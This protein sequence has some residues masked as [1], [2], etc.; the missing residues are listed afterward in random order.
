MIYISGMLQESILSDQLLKDLVFDK[1][2]F[3]PVGLPFSGLP[4]RHGNRKSISLILL[5]QT[6][7]DRSFSGSAE[8]GDNY[9]FS[10]HLSAS[11]RACG[12]SASSY[13]LMICLCLRFS[14]YKVTFSLPNMPERKILYRQDFSLFFLVGIR[15][16]KGSSPDRLGEEC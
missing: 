5:H 9:Q 2:I 13:V 15:I 11:S 6:T 12:I 7:D 14:R 8:A 10:F 16:C 3:H 1:V 4:G